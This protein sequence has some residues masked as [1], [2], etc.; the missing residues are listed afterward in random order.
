M[1]E[2]DGKTGFTWRDLLRPGCLIGLVGIAIILGSL[3]AYSFSNPS[4]DLVANPEA[5]RPGGS[6]KMLVWMVG[7]VGVTIFG[8]LIAFLEFRNK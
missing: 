4:T 7:G 3:I 8:A 1:L 6:I 2:V 5:V